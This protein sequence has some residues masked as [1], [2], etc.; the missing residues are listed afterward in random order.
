[1]GV[2]RVRAVD[3]QVDAEPGLNALG[4]RELSRP[5]H[6]AQ[7]ADYIIAS[8]EIFQPS[9]WRSERLPRVKAI[10]LLWQDEA[11]VGQKH[12]I[13]RRWARRSTRPSAP[14]EQRTASTSIYRGL[15]TAEGKGA[16]LVLPRCDSDGT[17][18]HV[19]EISATANGNLIDLFQ[20]QEPVN[21]LSS[22][23]T[24]PTRNTL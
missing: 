19:A 16:S 4:Y 15:C 3:Q 9:W 21:S 11:R 7:D 8:K 5:R 24:Q 22:L 1:M 10:E 17:T 23:R 2:R 12:G 14:H 13:T 6:R 20:P 18:L